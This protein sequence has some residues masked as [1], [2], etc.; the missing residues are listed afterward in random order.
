MVRF[1][2]FAVCGCAIALA[3]R[4]AEAKVHKHAP[5][6]AEDK[7]AAS[8]EHADDPKADDQPAKKPKHPKGWPLPA[9]G[10][11]ESGDPELIF[12]FDD[13]PNPKTTPAVLDALA[14]HHIHAVFFMV[15]EMAAN[16]Q[17]ADLID[18]IVREGH[19]IGNHTMTHQDLCRL[20]DDA[21]AEREIDDA[22]Q[23]IEKAS[24]LT[25]YWFRTPYGVRCE[26]V[27]NM[28]DARHLGHFH[29][30]LDPQEW[31]HGNAQKAIDYVE[32][33]VGKMNG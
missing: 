32:K 13:G 17:A 27:E 10:P 26:R 19:I 30:D 22:K 18:R 24:G 20:K 16:K 9:A 11:T 8:G 33:Q 31:K 23:T 4:G 6:K 12:T 21:R 1:A 25:M 5:A 14:K 2:K 15:G 3:A 7:K 29:W 28:L